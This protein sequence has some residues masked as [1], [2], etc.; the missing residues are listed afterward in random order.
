MLKID[1]NRSE[2][3]IDKAE[4]NAALILN[5]KMISTINTKHPPRTK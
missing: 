1:A 5:I 3:G 2:I 4:I